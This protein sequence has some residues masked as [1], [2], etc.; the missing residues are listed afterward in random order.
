[1]TVSSRTVSPVKP[2]DR[3]CDLLAGHAVDRTP[4]GEIAVPDQVVQTLTGLR[5]DQ[6]V[7]WAAR[8]AV[9]ERLGHDIV[10]ISFA[11]QPLDDAL[12][13]VRQWRTET[14]LFV[15]ALVPGLLASAL[16][17]W[18]EESLQDYWLHYPTQLFSLFAEAVLELQHLTDQIAA[19]GADVLMVEEPLA[20]REGLRWPIEALRQ[21]YFPFLTLLAR[22]AHREGLR[23]FLRATGAI[24]PI[25]EDIALAEIDGLQGLCVSDGISL[26]SVRDIVG[27]R[28]CLWGG[29]DAAWLSLPDVETWLAHQLRA[30]HSGPKGIP[31]ILGTRDGLLSTLHLIEVERL[32]AIWAA[33][34]SMP[35]RLGTTRPG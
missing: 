17:L 7:P 26:A 3:V 13:W 4:I 22:T 2:R 18:G 30:W 28:F 9:I 25:L 20:R 5:W 24:A 32:D 12:F 21:A 33:V 29:V 23:F 15:V 35:R 34:E 31:T 16:A 6:P 11:D 14:D 19:A 8:R 27:S 10:T 1:M